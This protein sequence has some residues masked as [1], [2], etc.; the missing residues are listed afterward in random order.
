ML[1]EAYEI[2]STVRKKMRRLEDVAPAAGSPS[3]VQSAMVEMRGHRDV[4][5]PTLLP[6]FSRALSFHAIEMVS[7]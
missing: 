4:S 3:T 6:N 2:L 5:P 7:S 1:S